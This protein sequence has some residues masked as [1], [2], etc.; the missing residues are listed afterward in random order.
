MK[1]AYLIL[2][3]AHP[4]QLAQLVARLDVPGVRFFIHVDANTPEQDFA[5]MQAAAPQAQWAPRQ[6]C[7]WGGFSLVAATLGLMEMALAEGCDWLVLLS[8][9]DY[10]A[11]HPDRIAATLAASPYS[12]YLDL[13]T[14]FDVRYRWQSWH[15]EALNGKLLGKLLQKFQRLGNK[16]GIR[17]AP[18]EPLK[19]IHAGSQWWM[20]SAP[21]AR[22]LLD[23][24]AQ[25]PQII[26]FFR[27]TLVPDEMFFQSVLMQIIPFRDLAPALRQIEWE[28]GS[29][30]PRAFTPADARRLVAGPALFARKFMP[31]GVAARAI[32][33]IID[34]D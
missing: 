21:A 33:Q 24:L 17:R 31:D 22:M 34:P 30:S 1:I 7:R 26:R 8:G 27:R 32:D 15:F 3:H 2:T 29:W 19:A 18:P 10:P 12:A 6:P 11:K 25:Q 5:A 16:M 9:Q 4:Q 20:M 14:D 23:Y 13:Q 28:A